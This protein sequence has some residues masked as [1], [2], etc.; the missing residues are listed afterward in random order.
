MARRNQE[1]LHTGG[2]WQAAEKQRGGNTEVPREA[3]ERNGNRREWLGPSVLILPYGGS[4]GE[5]QVTFGRS[6]SITTS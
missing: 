6:Q 5:K 1:A 4:F 2:S 3:L